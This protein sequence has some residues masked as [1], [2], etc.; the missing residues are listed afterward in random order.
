MLEHPSTEFIRRH[1]PLRTLFAGR[2]LRTS[3]KDPVEVD[4]N[5]FEVPWFARHFES[6]YLVDAVISIETIAHP[7]AREARRCFARRSNYS[8]QGSKALA[9]REKFLATLLSACAS[10]PHREPTAFPSRDAAMEHLRHV[11]GIAPLDDEP[12]VSIDTWLLRHRRI[13]AK[14]EDGSTIVTAPVLDDARVCFMLGQRIVAQS[15]IK[16]LETM[17]RVLSLSPGIRLCYAN[18]DSIHLSVADGDADEVLTTLRLW[19]GDS[20]GSF[21]IEAVA[22]RGL[23][24]E[25]GRY[26]LY[27]DGIEKFRNRSVGDRKRPFQSHAIHVTSRPIGDLHVPVR[28]T[29]QMERTMSDAYSL[30]LGD[31]GLVEQRMVEVGAGSSYASVLDDLG[32]NRRIYVPKRMAAFNRLVDRMEDDAPP[33]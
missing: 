20:M 7:L 17:E 9:D 1:N 15:R 16:L 26:W 19:A 30:S 24:L 31:E 25:P 33:P 29:I 21:K 3:L 2:R 11:H 14:R 5:E 6:V 8:A 18:I 22:R 13:A 32:T 23:W 27:S 28:M 10:R 12:D 4:L